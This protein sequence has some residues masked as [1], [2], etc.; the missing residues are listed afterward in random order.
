MIHGSKK[1][2]WNDK[3]LKLKTIN[4][5]LKVSLQALF[6]KVNIGIFNW[7]LPAVAPWW[8]S[9]QIPWERGQTLGPP[10]AKLSLFARQFSGTAI[11]LRWLLT[12]TSPPST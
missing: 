5:Y 6:E 12:Q 9:L 3:I 11:I 10:R 7:F 4:V 2:D 8:D 1:K